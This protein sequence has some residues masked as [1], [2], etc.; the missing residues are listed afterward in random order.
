MS[1]ENQLLRNTRRWIIGFM[2]GLALSGLTAFPIETLLN[3]VVSHIETVPDFTKDWILKVHNG[4]VQTN[5]A[6][7]FLSYG[8]DW[9][10]FAHVVLALLFIGP[11]RD[12]VKNI[13]VIQ[14]G[15]MACVLVIPLALICGPIRGIPFYWQLIDCSFG[16]TGFIPLFICFK[17]IKAIEKIR[18]GQ[19]ALH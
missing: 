1:T 14:F 9:L 18:S 16:V 12:P 4:V 5:N 8:T 10:A 15:M 11:Y 17:N 7:P 6:F 3:L 19:S 2:A 13:W